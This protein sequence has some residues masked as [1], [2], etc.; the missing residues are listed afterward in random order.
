MNVQVTYLK[1]NSIIK[2]PYLV[3]INIDTIF[4]IHWL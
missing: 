2:K 4:G 1:I 3:N